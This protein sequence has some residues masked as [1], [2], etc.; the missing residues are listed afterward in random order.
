MAHLTLK[1]SQLSAVIG[2]NGAG[3]AAHP[4]HRAGYNGLWS[5]TSVHAPHNCFV[6]SV[7]GLNLEHFMDDLFMTEEGG[8]IFEPRQLAMTLEHLSER[9]ARLV[10][11]A[12][13]LTEVSS[14]IGRAHV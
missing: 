10:H 14:Q 1:N 8:E 4:Q 5:L 7:A 13:P 9:E 12:S 11:G 3:D 6:P 2:D